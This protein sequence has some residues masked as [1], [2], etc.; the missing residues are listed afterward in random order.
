MNWPTEIFGPVAVVHTPE[1]LSDEQGHQLERYLTKLD[2]SRVIVDLDGAEAIDSQALESLLNV[3]E[4]LRSAGGDIRITVTNK[5]NR[6][7][8]EVTRLDQ[9]IEVFESVIDA[10]KSFA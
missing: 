4:T 3:Q 1:D 9:Q 8:L 10:V 7:I 6:K 2:Q 5:I